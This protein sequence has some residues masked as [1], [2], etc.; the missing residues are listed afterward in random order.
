[1]F[2]ALMT[3]MVV[4][5]LEAHQFNAVSAFTNSKLNET[6]YCKYSKSFHQSGKCLFLLQA[7]YRL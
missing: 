4:F 2:Q 6:V 1:M 7:L 5:N 3:I